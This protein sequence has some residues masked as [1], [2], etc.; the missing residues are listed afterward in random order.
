MIYCADIYSTDN[1]FYIP[2]KSTAGKRA[3]WDSNSDV[4]VKLLDPP[5]NNS[6]LSV[7]WVNGFATYCAR[8]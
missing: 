7:L 1:L 4:V 5:I 3:E 6:F 2:R 8:Q